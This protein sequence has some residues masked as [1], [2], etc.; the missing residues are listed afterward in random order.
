MYLTWPIIKTDWINQSK[1]KY[2]NQ[3]KTTH[4]TK[5]NQNHTGYNNWNYENYYKRI[6]VDNSRVEERI[7]TSN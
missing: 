2:S 5:P 7:A 1:L 3:T 4:S 6:T